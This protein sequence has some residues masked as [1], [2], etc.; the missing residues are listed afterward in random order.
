MIRALALAGALLLA[1]PAGM[2]EAQELEDELEET[3][4]LILDKALSV[5]IVARITEGNRETVWNMELT[6][7]TISGRAVTVRMEG[8]NLVVLAEFTP[9][10]ESDDSILLVA[11]GQTWIS[12]EGEDDVVYHPTFQSLPVRI[13]EPVVFFPLGADT[14]EGSDGLGV[15]GG[16]AASLGEF[17]I[18]LE[19]RV[20]PFVESAERS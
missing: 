4:N 6:R 8:S 15:P 2:V 16:D 20:S 19:I 11:Q 1:L 9:Y 5:H 7:V 12:H 10:R 18:E 3:L 14:D 13:G 17:N